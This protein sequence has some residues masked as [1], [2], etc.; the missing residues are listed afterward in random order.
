MKNYE[1]VDDCGNRYLQHPEFV[2]IWIKDDG[3]ECWSALVFDQVGE[4][5]IDCGEPAKQFSLHKNKEGYY[6][7]CTF[8][9]GKKLYPR[10]SRI[11]WECYHQEIIPD[12]FFVDHK[13]RITTDNRQSNLRLA[14]RY[15]NARNAKKKTKYDHPSCKYKG[16]YQYHGKWATPTRK[17]FQAQIVVDGKSK[18]LGRYTTALEAARAYD[19][20]AIEYYGSFACTN[21]SL[22][23][24]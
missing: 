24:L 6:C 16:V 13:N 20:A 2:H 8:S 23:L 21:V 15:Q 18:H 19:K 10:Y 17:N 9:A 4:P 12:G 5:Y 7:L 14:T 11:C 3:S 1:Y 22:G